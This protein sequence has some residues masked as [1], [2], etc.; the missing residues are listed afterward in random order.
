MSDYNKMK[1]TELRDELRNR[2]LDTT[3][4]KGEL[5]ARLQEDDNNSGGATVAAPASTSRAAAPA[6]EEPKPKAKRTKSE[7][8]ADL[9]EEGNK[10]KAKL[11]HKKDSYCNIPGEVFEDYDCMLNQTNIGQNNNKF[12]VIQIIKNG[13]NYAVYTRW[14]RVGEKGSDM[15]SPCGS[16]QESAF[17]EFEKK[18]KDKTGN[19]WSERHDFQ[20]QANKYTLIEIDHSAEEEIANKIAQLNE[21]EG[22]PTKV[23]KTVVKPSKLAS[24]T[25]ELMKL[26][27]DENMFKHA[28]E[29]FN[30]DVKKMPLGAISKSQIAKGYEVLLDIE[31]EVKS[32]KPS[33]QVLQTLT[34]KFYT[35]IPHSFGRSV[36]PVIKTAEMV[37]NKIDMLNV[38]GDIE[39]AQSLGNDKKQPVV[40]GEIEN[41]FDKN[42]VTLKTDLTPLQR[43][44]DMFTVIETY[45]NNTMGHRKVKLIDVFEVTRHGEDARFAKH[46]A[47]ENRKLLWHGT[48]TAVVAAILA[49]G[50]RIMPH[51]GGRVGKGIYLASENG[52]SAN[53]V[54]CSGNIGIMFLAEAT[55]GKE[56]HID[57]DDSSLVAPP[58]GFDSII[59]K[60]HTEPDPKKDIT[61]TFDG[62]EV[63]IPQG[64]PIPQPQW[65]H[66][67]FFQSE[68][69]LYQESQVRIRYLLKLRFD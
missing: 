31:K 40:E 57:R 9:K 28:M 61:R 17:K 14:G 45:T 11:T 63:V 49:S 69:L 43:G 25:Q 1:V 8:L 52:K 62:H 39:I 13:N 41:P 16:S 46:N 7:A 50:L 34:S 22:N 32:S 48:N 65:K 2:G 6:A 4:L 56:H 10:K 15:T 54:G 64:K 47:T 36:P 44:D 35:L 53:Y 33:T 66:S 51:S 29:E 12:Y 59:A 26:I 27:F 37:Q 58:K 21:K 20:A 23:S 3:G 38:L 5:V 19:K 60:G 30:I 55:L 42:Y 68:Y 67:T 18:F 24:E